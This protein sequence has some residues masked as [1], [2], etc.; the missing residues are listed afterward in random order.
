M[1]GKVALITGGTRGIGRAVAV[2]LASLGADVALFY[3]GNR[4][5]AEDALAEARA[6]GVR[7]AAFQCD[8]SD[9]EAV[10]RPPR[11]ACRG[12]LAARSGILICRGHE[13]PT[14]PLDRSH[15]AGGVRVLPVG[16][17][18]RLA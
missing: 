2:K 12:G 17:A 4:E 5:A 15:G 7:A 14:A 8:V 9:G 13:G 1:K 3:A 10:A 18:R 6:L 11:S 16:N